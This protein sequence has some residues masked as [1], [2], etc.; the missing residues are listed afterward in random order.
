MLII[1]LD[2]Y[3]SKIDVL[4][5]PLGPVSKTGDRGFTLKELDFRI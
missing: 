3:A 4:P 2:L 5:I 1:N